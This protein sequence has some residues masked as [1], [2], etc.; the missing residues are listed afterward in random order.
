M[1]NFFDY[2]ESS[3]C[4]C[5]EAR[6]LAGFKTYRVA[7]QSLLCSHP[8]NTLSMH[9]SPADVYLSSTLLACPNFF[10]LFII[11]ITHISIIIT[12]C[13]LI[14][15][16]IPFRLAEVDERI[17][18]ATLDPGGACPGYSVFQCCPHI[19]PGEVLVKMC[20]KRGPIRL[21]YL[22]NLLNYNYID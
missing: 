10:T 14:P 3:C 19:L 16:Q 5:A 21:R 11:Y 8:I 13:T 17:C 15:E 7:N 9:P 20:Y 18:S 12:Q 6:S 1:I 4:V 22:Q 2:L